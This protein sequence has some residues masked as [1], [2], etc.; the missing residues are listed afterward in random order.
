MSQPPAV[1]TTPTEDAT[2]ESAAPSRWRPPRPSRRAAAFG[3]GMI[4]LAAWSYMMWSQAA[5]LAAIEESLQALSLQSVEGDGG[6]ILSAPAV[7]GDAP[8]AEAPVAAPAPSEAP[9]AETPTAPA[10][11]LGQLIFTDGAD[12]W[13]CRDFE[14]REQALI[15][16]EANLPGDP[17]FLDFD[18]NAVPCDPLTPRD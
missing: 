9:L 10:R 1:D 16:Y 12:L 2:E 15:V 6:A 11:L 8:P 14:T 18:R 3:A 17:N 5:S 4:V 13:D 7:G